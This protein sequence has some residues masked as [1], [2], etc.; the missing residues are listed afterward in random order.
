MPRIAHKKS[1]DLEIEL[2]TA[3]IHPDGVLTGQVTRSTH[4]VSAETVLIIQ[5]LARSVVRQ[6]YQPMEGGSRQYVEK[7]SRFDLLGSSS[8]HQ[9]H[10]GPMH[11]ARFGKPQSWPFTIRLPATLCA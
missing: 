5:V 10:K 8:V 3:E 9:L 7:T 2:E 11:I 1:K 4:I 6:V